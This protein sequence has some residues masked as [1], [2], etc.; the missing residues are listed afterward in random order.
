MTPATVLLVVF[1]WGDTLMRDFRHPGPM[2][3]W[4]E[5]ELMHGVP[6]ALKALRGRFRLAVGTN[7]DNSGAALVRRALDRAGIGHFFEAVFASREMPAAK[8][9]PDFFRFVL[10]AMDE[11]AAG[12]VSVGNECAKDIAPAKAAGMRTILLDLDGRAGPC[13]EADAVARAWDEVPGLLSR[14]NAP[15]EERP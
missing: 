2:A 4:P 9:D 13:P 3:E 12:A 10:D 1:D 15:K 5:V 11:A 8:P 7:A 14:M 6:S